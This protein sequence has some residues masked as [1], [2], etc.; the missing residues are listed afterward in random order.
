MNDTFK[1]GIVNYACPVC[2]KVAD[3]QIIMNTKLTK[4]EADKIEQINNKTIGFS[5]HFCK[6]CQEIIDTKNC[7]FIVG[8]DVNKTID[9]NNPYRSGHIVAIKK[10]SN[11]GQAIYNAYGNT[12]MAYMDF[13]EMEQLNLISDAT[14]T[15]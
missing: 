13:K 8:V 14:N 10:D 4:K 6:E 7:L 11:L 12:P 3:S 5:K 2:G 9:R 15:D 1:I